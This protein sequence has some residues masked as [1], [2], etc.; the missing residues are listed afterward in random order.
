MTERPNELNKNEIVSHL[1]PFIIDGVTVTIEKDSKNQKF[2]IKLQNDSDEN[3]YILITHE[4]V[5]SFEYDS[6]SVFWFDWY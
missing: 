2:R 1:I 4:G 6:K 5:Y 3:D